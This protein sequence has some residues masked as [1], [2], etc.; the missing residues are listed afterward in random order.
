MNDILFITS[1]KDI[2][3]SKWHTFRRENE[4]YFNY[5]YN[6][7]NNID[8]TLIV[9]LDDDIKNELLSK[10]T[11]KKNII[12]DKLSNVD[13][14]YEKYLEEEQKI[15]SSIKFQRKI[16]KHRFRINAETW[17]AKYTLI[18][19][20]KVNLISHSKK[21]YPEYKFYSWIDFGYI[22]DFDSIPK[23][24]NVNN[25]PEKII[26]Q[27]LQMPSKRLNALQMLQTDDVFISGGAFIIA[28]N[29][30]EKFESM[31]ENKIKLW[32]HN[33]ICDDDQSLVLQLYHENKD[34]FYLIDDPTWFAFYKHIALMRL[35]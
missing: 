22:R 29:L 3:R 14:F 20:S 6:L 5:F 33:F 24:I 21:K 1:F 2:G 27:A 4:E 15:I 25:I 8:Y 10:Y 35:K 19:H 31:Y 12:F 18:N 30:V 7:A 17:S 9:Y 23:N 16:P 34:I 26:Y 13:T 11:F 28:N 32:H